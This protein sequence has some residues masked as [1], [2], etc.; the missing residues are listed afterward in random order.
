MK[1]YVWAI[2]IILVA[3]AGIFYGYRWGNPPTVSVVMLTYKRAYMLPKA[4]ES[5]LAQTY[6]DFEFIILNDG[7]PDNTDEIMKK[8]T[9]SRIRYYKN[10]ENKGI[11]Y[12]R[13]RATSLARGKYVMIMDDD[14]ISL[15]ERM[16]LQVDYLETHP[17]ITVVA[18]QIIGSPLV[19]ESHDD[20][21]VGLIQYHNLGNAN[22][23]YRREFITKHKIMYKEDIEYGED[24]YFWLQMLFSGAHFA[25]MSDDVVIRNAYTLK[26]YKIDVP[27]LNKQVTEYVGCFFSPENPKAFYEA[28]V[29]EKLK[30]IAP[31]H[32]L[33]EEYMEQLQT[34]NNCR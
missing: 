22:I 28:D 15:P 32:I 17:E 14:D 20:I 27:H 11:A 16:K 34:A 8:Y 4:I 5:I 24:W 2:V 9:D 33:S 30:M 10:S 13:N 29:C 7:S 18:G 21:V 12:S 25:S 6:K 23:M 19:P 26:H 1:R 3:I 31:K